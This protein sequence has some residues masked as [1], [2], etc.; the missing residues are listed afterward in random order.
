MAIWDIYTYIYIIYTYI[1]RAARRVFVHILARTNID[2][3]V[4]RVY[5]SSLDCT[6][7]SLV[8]PLSPPSFSLN[9]FRHES[10][11]RSAPSDC[12]LLF[13]DIVVIER[14]R[15]SSSAIIPHAWQSSN[16]REFTRLDRD[17]WRLAAVFFSLYCAPLPPPRTNE[18]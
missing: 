12:A 10:D 11:R 2:D 18:G 7:C 13:R 4:I 8:R 17:Q 6:T 1:C 16:G 9:S 15:R 5:A 14:D 3:S